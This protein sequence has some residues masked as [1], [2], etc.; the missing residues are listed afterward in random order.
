MGPVRGMADS[1]CRA[2]YIAS[3]TGGRS[4]HYNPA[5]MILSYISMDIS[6]VKFD[7]LNVKVLMRLL[8]LENHLGGNLLLNCLL[9]PH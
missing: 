1:K 5:V 2:T 6:M 4:Q 8:I 7:Y 3:H 9:N